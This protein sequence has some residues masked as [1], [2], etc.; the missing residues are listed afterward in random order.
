MKVKKE[1]L[2]GEERYISHDRTWKERENEWTMRTWL[3]SRTQEERD[4]AKV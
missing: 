1:K 4:I 2:E 3:K